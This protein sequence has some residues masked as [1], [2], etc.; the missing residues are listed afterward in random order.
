MAPLG[1]APLE[2]KKLFQNKSGTELVPVDT[3]AEKR[4]RFKRAR[5]IKDIETTKLALTPGG[6]PGSAS[7]TPAE[8]GEAL[9]TAARR[10]VAR[11]R[12][13]QGERRFSAWK[14][15][16]VDSVVGA[17]LTQNVSDTV[18]RQVVLNHPGS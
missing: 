2:P 6:E 12:V 4:R 14:G 15:S 8:G 7:L 5:V 13:V 1:G 9:E 11:V 18:S 16:V 10:F 17:F 3:V